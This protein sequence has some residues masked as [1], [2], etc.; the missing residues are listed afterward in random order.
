[1]SETAT[2]TFE[3][4]ITPADD[5]LGLG[6]FLIAK[7]WSGD[8]TGE[9][10]GRMLSA[11]DPAT[12]SAGY[13]AVEVVTGSLHGRDGSFAF[14]QYGV[15]RPGGQELTYAVVPGSGAGDLAGIEG[16]LALTR[17]DRG[18]SYALTFTLPD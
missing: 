5:E 3:V 14:Q 12:G 18:H 2:G 9:G 17:D 4:T 11:G 15:M 7:T 16:T 1:M 8:L 13:V 6:H 10:H